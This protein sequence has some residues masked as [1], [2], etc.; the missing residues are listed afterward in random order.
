MAR[1][2]IILNGNSSD[3]IA[4]LLIQELPPITKPAIR[5]EVETID[6]RDG[7][8]TTKLGYSAYNKEISIGLYGDF[9]IN[10]VIAFFDSEGT[11]TFSNEEDKYY[12]YQIFEQIDFERLVR[13]RTAKVKMHVQ[14]FKFSTEETTKTFNVNSNLLTIPDFT[15]TSNGVTLTAS[16]GAVTISGTPTAATEFYLP[17]TGVSLEPGSYT[18]TA[19]ATGTN[20]N[21]CSIR[22]I[23]SAPSD[24]DS[25]GGQYITL[26]NESSVTLSDTLAASKTFGYLWFY[27]NAGTALDFSMTASLINDNASKAIAI[28]ND[29]NIFS[30]P[31]ITLMGDGTVNLS[32]NGE[33]IFVI[34]LDSAGGNITIDATAMEAYQGTT[35]T[36]MNRY[37]DGDYDNLKL[38]TGANSITW[39]GNLTQ[40]IINNYSRWI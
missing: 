18:L 9:D 37:V 11:V 16:N 12:Y 5:T 36:L 19:T 25:F 28:T 24:A 39:T 33:Q 22:L 14:P 29:G 20:E 2:S 7:D 40:I 35:S 8:I 26:A 10:E 31:Q 3:D 27:M 1:N 6:G 23:G 38:N 21:Y 30:R 32:L 34:D 4:G 15:R 17:V 13:F